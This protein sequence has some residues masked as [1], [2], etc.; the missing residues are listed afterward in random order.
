MLQK[1]VFKGKESWVDHGWEMEIPGR[2]LKDGDKKDSLCRDG[3]LVQHE[4]TQGFLAVRLRR[5]I[6]KVSMVAE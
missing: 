1:L 5:E 4:V 3:N 6:V 2:F